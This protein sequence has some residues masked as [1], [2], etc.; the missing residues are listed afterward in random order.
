MPIT[1]S[2]LLAAGVLSAA[3]AVAGA[4]AVP[5]TAQAAG[6]TATTS[7]AER[8]RLDKLPT[9]KLGWYKCYGTAEC[10]TV[11]VPL[12]YDKPKGAKTE[13]AV[14]RVKAKNQKAKIGSLFVNPGGPGG[15]ATAMAA[16]A[17]LFLSDAV[18]EKFDVVGVDPRGIGAS[19]NIKC[20]KSVKDQTAV[21]NRMNV[22]FPLGKTQEQRYISGAQSFGK[23]CSTTGKTLAGAMSTSEVARDMELMRRAVGDKKLT[24]LGFSYGTA[25]GQYYANL[26]PDRFRA[27]AIDGNIDPRQWAGTGSSGNQ[28]LDAG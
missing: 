25:L 28:I 16:D 23:A 3:V 12:D 15:S 26:F 27:I 11:K 13:I 17:P 8:R 6:K 18:L 1:R 2:R 9:P 21:F 4:V 7:A 20:F 14:L 24:Y 10:A 5:A 19:A 22:A